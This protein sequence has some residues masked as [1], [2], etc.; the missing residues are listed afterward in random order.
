[1]NASTPSSPPFERRYGFKSSK[2]GAYKGLGVR[3]PGVR[4]M[5]L[6]CAER[7]PPA[8]P[9]ADFPAVAAC[10]AHA[11]AE[12]ELLTLLRQSQRTSGVYSLLSYAN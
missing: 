3:C 4:V 12:A 2:V 11:I 9:T 6:L 10:P 7:N 5:L 1:M 8:G